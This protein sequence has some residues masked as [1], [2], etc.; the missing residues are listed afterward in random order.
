M[1]EGAAAHQGNQGETDRERE[2]ERE[3]E[4]KVCNKLGRFGR[5]DPTFPYQ[6]RNLSAN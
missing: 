4:T 3:R 1:Q 5:S 6:P 2:R